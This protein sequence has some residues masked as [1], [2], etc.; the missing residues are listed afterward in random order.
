MSQGA[1]VALKYTIANPDNVEKLV[2]ISPGGVIPDKISFVFR[3]VFYS[4]LGRWG[5][6][7]MARMLYADQRVPASAEEMIA[8][9]IHN[10]RTRMGILPLFSDEE[11]QRLT[12]PTLLLGGIKDALRDI[13][14]IAI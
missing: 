11:L 12:M 5:V 4:L 14:Q 9:M 10:F 1:W 8:I 6:K 13:E 3:A 2:L 7:R